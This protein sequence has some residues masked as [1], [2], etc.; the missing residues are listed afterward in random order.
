MIHYRDI[1]PGENV[2]D[3]LACAIQNSREF[4]VVIT[5]GFLDS[6]WCTFELDTILSE[7]SIRKKSIET[8][9]PIVHGKA[10]SNVNQATASLILDHHNYLE[11]R[12]SSNEEN[13]KE[14]K[15]NK[16]LF[17]KQLV[18]RLYGGSDGCCC[19]FYG[20]TAIG[21]ADLREHTE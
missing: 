6:S 18:N 2:I 19:P 20:S 7:I 5:Q 1:K 3:K 4:I 8:I 15:A 13:S 17:W 9:I 11:W 12:L 16:K 21:H 14:D 10:P